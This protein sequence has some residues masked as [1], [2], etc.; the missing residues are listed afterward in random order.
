MN[1][2]ERVLKLHLEIPAD[3]EELDILRAYGKAENGLIRD[4]LVPSSMSLHQLHFLIQKAFGWK[5]AH[6][7]HFK[8]PEEV[9]RTV[10]RNQFTRWGQFCGVYFR[11]PSEDYEDL[12]WDDDYNHWQDPDAWM[13]SKYRGVPS[14]RGCLEHF[15]EAQ[16]AY[17]EMVDGNPIVRVSL[18]F[19]EWSERKKVGKST[20]ATQKDI[21]ET[22]VEEIPLCFAEFATMD[23]LLER[24]TLGELL[25]KKPAVD[26][27]LLDRLAEEA[28]WV[29]WKGF[30]E[31]ERVQSWVK[32]PTEVKRKDRV[33]QYSM[34]ELDREAV[35]VTSSLHYEYDYGDG[36]EVRIQL[37]D[38]L[39]IAEYEK[40]TPETRADLEKGY[41]VCTKVDG[42]QVVDDIGGMP[43][44]CDFLAVLFGSGSHSDERSD[45]RDWARSMGWSARVKTMKSC[46]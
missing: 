23:E 34:K 21:R 11:F 16:T 12:Y 30:L 19:T 5:N 2:F 1:S 3:D 46:I 35:P 38:I 25:A 9:F 10:T 6:L 32:K 13:K 36:W 33:Y 14:Y 42:V 28:E 29:Y 44:F 20:D 15:A 31:N 45:M 40:L 24:L 39:S 4:V 26:Q 41:P 18:P 43:G 8:L 22:T 7:H 17:R 37:I 27:I